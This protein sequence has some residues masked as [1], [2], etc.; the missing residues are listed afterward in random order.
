MGIRVTHIYEACAKLPCLGIAYMMVWTGTYSLALYG[1]YCHCSKTPPCAD[2]IRAGGHSSAHEGTFPEASSWLFWAAPNDIN[3]TL[4][5]PTR[6]F[7]EISETLFPARTIS[8]R[9][10]RNVAWSWEGHLCL[11]PVENS[12]DTSWTE[13]K[14][15]FSDLLQKWRVTATQGQRR[16]KVY[17]WVGSSWQGNAHL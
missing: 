7:L 10:N 13:H 4:K 8:S 17:V 16:H 12:V 5:L 2:H 9:W 3:A 15:L 1:S 6:Y 11:M 14:S